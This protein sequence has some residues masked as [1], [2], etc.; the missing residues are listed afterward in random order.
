[1]SLNSRSRLVTIVLDLFFLGNFLSFA[2]GV[3]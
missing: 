2:A 3:C 1:M